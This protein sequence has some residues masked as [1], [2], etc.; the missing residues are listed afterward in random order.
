MEVRREEEEDRSRML[1]L[2]R[3]GEEDRSRGLLLKRRL[4]YCT[5]WI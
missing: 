3:R 1:L 5:H 4:L 2:K